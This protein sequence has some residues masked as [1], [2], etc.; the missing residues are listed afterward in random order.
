MNQE[1]KK[2]LHGLYYHRLAIG[3]SIT[4]AANELGWLVKASYSQGKDWTGKDGRLKTLKVADECWP[5]EQSLFTNRAYRPLTYLH[6]AGYIFMSASS[7]LLPSIQ[8]TR[9]GA[10]LAREL[11]TRHGRCGLWYKEHKDGLLG[12]LITILV[13]ALTA[14]ITS[15]V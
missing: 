7:F 12:L 6:D 1:E 14:A 2:I 15:R 5:S 10:D 4:Y 3:E 11:G 9:E 8:V 13:S